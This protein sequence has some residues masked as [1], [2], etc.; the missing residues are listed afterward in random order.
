MA[1]FKKRQ[2]GETPSDAELTFLTAD[3]ADRVRS[4]FREAFAGLGL[5]VTVYAGHAQDASGRQFGL[6][7]LAA[8]CHNDERGEKVWP[9]VVREHVQRVIANLDAPSPFEELSAD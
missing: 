4:L 8:A 1:L 6:W 3:Q 5:E 7:N 2:Q 9:Q